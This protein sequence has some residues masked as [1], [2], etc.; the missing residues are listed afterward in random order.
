[1]TK[2]GKLS[3]DDAIH[4]MWEL[5][6]SIG[7]GMLVTWAGER[8]RARPVAARPHRHENAIYVLADE[9]GAKDDDIRRFPIVSL[10]F[11]DIRTHTYLAITGCAGV[12]NDRAR[13]REL[14]SV[15][16]RAWWETADD[17]AI[18]LISFRPEDAQIWGG[19]GRFR[20]AVALLGAAV[21][22]ANP[23]FGDNRKIDGL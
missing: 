16:D 9:A 18:R 23:D 7:I 4:T 20:T 17:P 15:S 3:R 10:A 14:F 21:S 11:A 12:S 5:V 1:M 8:Q 22:G 6:E 2:F 19:L 13:I